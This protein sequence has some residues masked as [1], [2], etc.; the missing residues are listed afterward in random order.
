MAV[1]QTYRLFEQ[2]H[3]WQRVPEIAKGAV[4][5]AA[6]NGCLAM[7]GSRHSLLCSRL[8]GLSI[9]LTMGTLW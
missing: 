7:G 9:N 2:R 5:A 1:L 3:D 6:L 8:A 4:A